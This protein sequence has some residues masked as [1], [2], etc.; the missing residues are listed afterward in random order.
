MALILT[1]STLPV[2]YTHLDV[3][4]RQTVVSAK[5]AMPV[6]G[7]S[8]IVKGNQRIGTSTDAEGNFKLALPEALS[9]T[10]VTIVVSFI[11]YEPYELTLS[12]SQTSVTVQLKESAQELAEVV[13]TA[14]GIKKDKK[15]VSLSLI[16]I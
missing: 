5:D 6:V 3:Y 13:V 15:A 4:K 12:P 7:A 9:T 10:T 16:H 14:L 8:V 11:G 1:L 2:S